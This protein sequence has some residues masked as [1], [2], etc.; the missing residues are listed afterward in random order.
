M[1]M[2]NSSTTPTITTTM[3]LHHL[4]SL[5]L[6]AIQPCLAQIYNFTGSNN[7]TRAPDPVWEFIV[8]PPNNRTCDQIFNTTNTNEILLF[9]VP[10][11]LSHIGDCYNFQALFNGTVPWRNNASTDV[12]TFQNEDN[13]N[14]YDTKA[15]YSDV[16]FHAG[17]FDGTNRTQLKLTMYQS[18]DCSYN[19]AT[20]LPWFQWGGCDRVQERQCKQLPYSLG[21]FKIEQTGSTTCEIGAQLGKSATVRV[22]PVAA[23]LVTLVAFAVVL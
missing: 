2:P 17:G 7:R 9:A 11:P 16:S 4:S 22:G 10:S 14:I 12:Y 23:L 6:I 1:R 21:S 18:K 15:N 19:N 13:Q 8:A 5:L 3:L 20:D